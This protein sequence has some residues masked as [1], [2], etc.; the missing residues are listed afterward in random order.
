MG[1]GF[2][3][4]ERARILEGD[5]GLHIIYS[6][7]THKA[8][9]SYS[10]P[11]QS[12]IPA[13]TDPHNS[14]HSFLRGSGRLGAATAITDDFLRRQAYFD[15]LLLCLE[16]LRLFPSMFSTCVREKSLASACRSLPL[17]LQY[18]YLNLYRPSTFVAVTP[19]T[20]S[21]CTI[22]HNYMKSLFLTSFKSKLRCMSVDSTIPVLRLSVPVVRTKSAVRILLLVQ[23]LRILFALSTDLSS[24]SNSCLFSRQKARQSTMILAACPVPKRVA[25]LLMPVMIELYCSDSTTS[26]VRMMLRHIG[27]YQVMINVTV[28]DQWCT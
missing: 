14:S 26:R 24:V 22:I 8:Q 12:T 6:R 1:E 28:L 7:I 19:V 21:Q 17:S 23:A 16:L 5:C 18:D 27:Y 2:R 9:Y 10:P 25:R 4:L 20:S 13:M 3:P 15:A 11:L